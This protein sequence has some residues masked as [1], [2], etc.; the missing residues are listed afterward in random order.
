VAVRVCSVAV[1]IASVGWVVG[2]DVCVGL[3]RAVGS[4]ARRVTVG[5]TIM[6]T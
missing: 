6:A 3:A 2:D 4:A 5:V 1:G